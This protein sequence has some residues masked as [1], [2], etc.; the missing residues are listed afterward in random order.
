MS[1]LSTVT[2]Q[3][4]QAGLDGRD[5][6]VE[7]VVGLLAG[8][9]FRTI[10]A[11]GP[12]E[13]DDAG[14]AAAG[15]SRG[16]VCLDAV[17]AVHDEV[18]HERVRVGDDERSVDSGDLE[19]RATELRVEAEDALG[20]L[21][22]LELVERA[23]VGGHGDGELLA[24]PRP[25][26]DDPGFARLRGDG[27][28]PCDGPEQLHE[29]REVVRSDVEERSRALLEEEVG[30][31]VPGL[32]T[33]ALHQRERRERRADRAVLDQPPSGLD[34][35][36]EERVGRRGDTQTLR[37]RR[38]EQQL[39]ALAV[40]RER[41]LAPDV[42]ARLE[43]PESDLH[44]HLRQGEVDDDLDL[45]VSEQLVDRAVPGDAEGLG[46]G[47]RALLVDVGDESHLDVGEGGEVLQV[48]RADDAG[49]DD[50]DSDRAAAHARPFEVRKV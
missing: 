47:P 12:C 21:A 29:R 49:A 37:V 30:V 3:T 19:L 31:R 25:R 16:R 45:V 1:V 8:S 44:V 33:R 38:L 14:A 20:R 36:A 9:A 40:E 35:R 10:G 41:L 24:R 48:L 2:G 23:H 28:H 27:R 50:A 18:P 26:A 42:L 34:A 13:L 39:S 32:R 7:H 22:A 4:A 6:D 15:R 46:L 11:D 5:H 43:R 17:G